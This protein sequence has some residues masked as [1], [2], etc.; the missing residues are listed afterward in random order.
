MSEPVSASLIIF[1]IIALV[2][3]TAFGVYFVNKRNIK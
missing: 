3:I 2:A 1:T